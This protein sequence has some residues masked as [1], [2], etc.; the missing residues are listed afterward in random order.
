MNVEITGYRPEFGTYFGSL[1]KAWLRTYFSLEPMDEYVLG[2]PEEAVIGRGGHILFA[3]VG[4]RVVGTVALIPANNERA[5]LAKLAVDEQ[6]RRLG[7][8]DR[9][10]KAVIEYPPYQVHI[11]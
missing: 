8:G 3:L 5:E 11:S 7:I 4:G 2:N 1:N 6:Y 9:L 10:V